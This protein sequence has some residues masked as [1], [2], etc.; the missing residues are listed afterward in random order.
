MK[1]QLM[2]ME[3]LSRLARNIGHDRELRDAAI[4]ELAK[5]ENNYRH[6]RGS[7]SVR[8]L[9]PLSYGEYYL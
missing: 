1:L 9:T 6:S 8:A 7:G 2:S 3:D 4:R 5:R